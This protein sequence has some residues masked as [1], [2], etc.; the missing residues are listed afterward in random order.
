MCQMVEVLGGKQSRVR[1][2]WEVRCFIENKGRSFWRCNKPEPEGSQEE[3]GMQRFEEEY[4]RHESS[5]FSNSASLNWEC[6]AFYFYFFRISKE[7]NVGR[8]QWKVNGKLN[9]KKGWESDH[10]V[11][12]GQKK[13]FE[14]YSAWW[15]FSRE[16][17]WFE[18]LLK[19]ITHAAMGET[20]CSEVT[21]D[22][23]RSIRKLLQYGSLD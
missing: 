9:W 22:T 16:V 8:A 17:T 11:L 4:L 12:V 1:G 21:V 13:Y 10:A 14:L 2:R 19:S 6:A 20:V 5:K 15:V 3:K 7:A 23:R 18:L